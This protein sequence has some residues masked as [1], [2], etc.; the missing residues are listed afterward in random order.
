MPIWCVSLIVSVPK[1][2]TCSVKFASRLTVSLLRCLFQSRNRDTFLFN[3]VI[4][5]DETGGNV[6]FQSRN[7]DTFLFN[8]ANAFISSQSRPSFNLAIEILFFSTFKHFLWARPQYTRF[9]LAIEILF[10]STQSLARQQL[11]LG[12]FNLAIE[13]LFFSTAIY[14]N[15]DDTCRRGC[16]F[17]EWRFLSWQKERKKYDKRFHLVYRRLCKRL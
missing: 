10:F 5:G 6:V 11:G 1:K 4:I 8:T 16:Y 17:C 9:N 2:S 12:S 14:W 7:R 15:S 3:S 13:I